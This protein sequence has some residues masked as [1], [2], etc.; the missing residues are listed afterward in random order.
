[1]AQ[2]AGLV[3]VA[4]EQLFEAVAVLVQLCQ[5]LKPI[6]RIPR[7]AEELAAVSDASVAIAVESEERVDEMA[8]KA[9]AAGPDPYSAA[10]LVDIRTRISK[11]MD[12]AYVISQ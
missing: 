4:C 7:I 5:G 12:A 10:H 3:D 11:A 9:Q 6:F 2:L 1:M 8:E